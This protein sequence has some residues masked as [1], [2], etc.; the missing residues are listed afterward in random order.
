MNLGFIRRRRRGL[1]SALAAAGALSLGMLFPAVAHA[2][3]GGFGGGY[4]GGFG[5]GGLYGGQT[6]VVG[7]IQG[8]I[9][10]LDFDRGLIRIRAGGGTTV[11]L[12]ARPQDLVGLNPGDV[13]SVSYLNYNGVLWLY[14]DGGGYG[15]GYGGGGGF[16]VGGGFG[17]VGDF[18]QAG[19]VTGTVQNVDRQRGRITI[20]G[21]TLRAHPEELENVYPGQFV[22]VGFV[23]IGKSRWVDDYGGG[24][25]GGFGGGGL[26]GFGGDGF[27][28]DGFG[29]G[30]GGGFNDRGLIGGGGGGGNGGGN[31]GAIEPGTTGSAGGDGGSGTSGGTSGGTG[32]GASGDPLGNV[33][34][35]GG[36]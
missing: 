16:G 9:Q 24:F 11:A 8:P 13:A 32:G 10:S 33:G 3:I 23:Q 30:G 5:G 15:G 6:E 26:G 25:G 28:G 34:T 31:G 36:R 21:R 17:G 35:G 2:Q 18:A 29:V 4:G 20:S 22:S 1:L 27:G 14:P 19:E 12:N 7:T